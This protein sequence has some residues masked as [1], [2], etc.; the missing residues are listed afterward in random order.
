MEPNKKSTDRKI[1]ISHR[2]WADMVNMVKKIH[3]NS[4]AILTEKEKSILNS[5]DKND[6]PAC[7]PECTDFHQRKIPFDF[8]TR[9][10][11]YITTSEDF[12]E[13]DRAVILKAIMNYGKDEG[14]PT[15]KLTV[16]VIKEFR[17]AITKPFEGL[18]N[19]VSELNE[20][21]QK[22]SKD[23]HSKD[24]QTEELLKEISFLSKSLQS[25]LKKS[26]GEV[27]SS[28]EKV[29]DAFDKKLP[30]EEIIG[31]IKTQNR[32]FIKY[33]EE[34]SKK[35]TKDP[36]TGVFNRATFEQ[37]YKKTFADC[38]KTKTPLSF[39][40]FDIDKF[41]RINDTYGH[42]VGDDAIR[43]VVQSVQEG[44]TSDS[45]F[46]AR[47][48]GEEFVAVLKGYD[49]NKAYSIAQSIRLNIE[50]KPFPIKDKDITEK[51]TISI[52]ASQLDDTIKDGAALIQIADESLY[53]AKNT[54]RNKVCAIQKV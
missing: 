29:V 24:A 35:A 19:S 36:L 25:I 41:K 51:I 27:V 11:A 9:V 10:I 15:E 30:S 34:E 44:I 3:L 38:E 21:V 13:D 45:I 33:L 20:T 47:Y 39:L 12:A 16:H 48:G 2:H 1:M 17:K 18:E 49:L 8:D 53:K 32:K 46:L 26:A 23:I 7:N 4:S 37:H 22:L 28:E 50:K 40:I 5:L 43:F 31:L 6:I 54:G 52:G 14:Q 42:P